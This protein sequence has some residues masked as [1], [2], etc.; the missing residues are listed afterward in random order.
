MQKNNNKWIGFIPYLIVLVAIMSLFSMNNGSSSSLTYSELR[1]VLTTQTIDESVI[2]MSSN[3]IGVRGTYLDEDGKTV[4]FTSTVPA[5]AE[6]VSQLLEQLQD[7]KVSVV[8]S[9][10]SNSF[11][12]VLISLI[13]FV[14]IG[15]LAI[16]M[17][18]R[19]NGA[20]GANAKAFEFSK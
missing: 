16:W 19:M 6:E 14:G 4:S 5:T 8:D 13:P 9:D 3:V 2:S 7:S 17:M 10:S 12:N 15:I 11:V 18:N 20:G 1:E